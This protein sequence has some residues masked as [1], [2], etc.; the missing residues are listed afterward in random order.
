MAP[1]PVAVLTHATDVN[2]SSGPANGFPT[3]VTIPSATQGFIPGN[4]IVPEYLNDI[5][6]LLD[7]YTDWIFDGSATSGANPHIVETDAFGSTAVTN[8]TVD[9]QLFV[10]NEAVIN[11]LLQF[12]HTG[13][14]VTEAE[15]IQFADASLGA[16]PR[17]GIFVKARAGRDQ[18]PAAGINNDGSQIELNPNR[19]GTGLT[20]QDGGPGVILVPDSGLVVGGV[21]GR[22]VECVFCFNQSGVVRE[23]QMPRAMYDL[24]SFVGYAIAKVICTDDGGATAYMSEGTF[25][26]LTGTGIGATEDNYSHAD[27]GQPAWTVGP[28]ILTWQKPSATN[29][30]LEIDEQSGGD[31]SGTVHVTFVAV[32]YTP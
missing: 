13:F 3:K 31:I 29:L 25:I 8:L 7:Q 1:K 16:D 21:S 23:Y 26:Y 4:N 2:Y 32:D 15:V 11:F 14:Q 28:P 18:T 22:K 10:D 6:N 30:N 9:D 17:S 27:A 19:P 5:L 12:G 24:T 20:T